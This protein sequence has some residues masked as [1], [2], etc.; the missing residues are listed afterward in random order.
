MSEQNQPA[1]A[2]DQPPEVEAEL[3]LPKTTAVSEKEPEVKPAEVESPQKPESASSLS[4]WQRLRGWYTGHKKLSIPLSVVALLLLL[5]AIPTTRYPLAGLVLKKNFTLQV[6]DQTTNTPVSGATVSFGSISSLTDGNGKVKLRLAVGHHN[7]SIVKKYYQDRRADVL[8]PI[9]GQK[10][11]PVISAQ[12]TGRQVQ[13]TI[14]NTVSSK[15]L[16]DVD[17]K[18][19]DITAKTDKDGK[20]LIVLPAGVATQKASLSLNGYNSADATIK[21]SDTVVAQNNF[22]ITPAG[23]VYFLSKQSGKIDVVKSN[24]DGTGRET[25]LA[26]TGREDNQ[27]TV[28]LASRDWKYLALLSRR[29]SDLAKLYMIETSSDKVT[30]VDEGNATFNLIG[31]SDANFIYQVDRIGYQQ[32]QPKQHALKGYNA[33]SKKI[34]ILD[35]TDAQGSNNSDYNYENFSDVYI[36]GQRV[37]FAKSWYSTY[38]DND[39]LGDNQL[40]IY[41][42]SA[43]GSGGRSTHKTFGYA[44]NQSTYLQ[45]FPSKPNQINFQVVEKSGGPSYFVYLGGQV[46]EK[47]SIKDDFD[48]YLN[49]GQY[50]TYLASPSGN[51]TFWSESRDGK[52]SLFT[53]DASGGSAKQIAALSDY[54]TYGW[55]GED[56]LM[57]SKNGSE[58]Y[59]LASDGIKKDSDALKITDYHKPVVSYPG[60]G[61]M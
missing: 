12:A 49:G 15:T 36:V 42:I 8:V 46:S 21:V 44:P 9:L 45:S 55:Y 39:S 61:G 5:L 16:A 54:Q 60:Y 18:V 51:S 3:P 57:V 37:I 53:G 24:L 23:K 11:P 50:N 52:N 38:Y 2:P 48:S 29:D 4:R 41:S 19:L 6:I 33:T 43:A 22:T 7:I 47:S 56:Y 13:V 30:A 26:G 27:N 20:A 28:L 31:W 17:I 34:T 32:W 58:L 35:E 25:V 1:K 59:I 40:G 10:A 14:K